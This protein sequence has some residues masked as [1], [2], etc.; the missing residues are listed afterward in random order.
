MKL[1][2]LNTCITKIIKLNLQSFGLIRNFL[3]SNYSISFQDVHTFCIF[4]LKFLVVPVFSVYPFKPNNY[5][6]LLFY[7]GQKRNFICWIYFIKNIDF[8]KNPT[9]ISKTQ[10]CCNLSSLI[11]KNDIKWWCCHSN[12][13]HIKIWIFKNHVLE[14]LVVMQ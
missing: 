6:L 2:K 13:K 12:R 3:Y 10:F 5:K 7:F 8:E 11:I 14:F 9:K 1:K 4:K